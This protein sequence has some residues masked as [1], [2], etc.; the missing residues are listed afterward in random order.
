MYFQVFQLQLKGQLFAKPNAPALSPEGYALIID[1]E[2]GGKEYYNKFLKYPTVP[3]GYSG[4][5]WGAGFDGQFYSKEN[6]IRIWS[7]LGPDKTLRLSK[8]SGLNHSK[9][10][11]YLPKVKDILIDWDLA[12]EVFNEETIP[13]FYQA[14]ARTYPGLSELK[15]NAV[16]AIVSLVFNRGTSFVGPNRLE[17][18]ELKPAIA[19][20]DYKEMARLIRKMK[21]IWDGKNQNGLIIRREKEALLIE[22]CIK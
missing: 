14:A 1:S 18:K 16:A 13:L 10:L 15:P 21:K 7:K 20:Q 5:T 11:V 19:R 22:S 17:M 3:P 2:T 8:T 9:S 12:T 4:V 6:I